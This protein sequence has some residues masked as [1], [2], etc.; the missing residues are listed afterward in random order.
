MVPAANE[1]KRLSS[2]NR[3]TKKIINNRETTYGFE[4]ILRFFSKFFT[5]ETTDTTFQLSI[6]QH[7][8]KH[9]MKRLVV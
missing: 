9:I 1:A 2:V 7:F 8:F 5:I 6:K 3:T 4:T